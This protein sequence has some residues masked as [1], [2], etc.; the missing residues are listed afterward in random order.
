MKLSAIVEIL[1]NI[2]QQ[3]NCRTE[4]YSDH[5]MWTAESMKRKKGGGGAFGSY[6]RIIVFGKK[7]SPEIFQIKNWK[8]IPVKVHNSFQSNWF[9]PLN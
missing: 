7:K 1:D 8:L 5:Y 4:H 2:K 6:F 3:K 9:F